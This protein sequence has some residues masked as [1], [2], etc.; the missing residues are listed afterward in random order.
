MELI[1]PYTWLAYADE[2]ILLEEFKYNA[3]E[4]ACKKAIIIQKKYGTTY[5]RRQDLMNGD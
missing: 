3:E 5:K 2:I 4:S 1:G